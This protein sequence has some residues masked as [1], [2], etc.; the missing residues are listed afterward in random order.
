M[1]PVVRWRWSGMRRIDASISLAWGWIA[2]VL[3]FFY[4]LGEF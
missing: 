4:F 1:T 2:V 3:V